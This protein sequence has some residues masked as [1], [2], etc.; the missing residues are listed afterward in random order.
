VTTHRTHADES[1]TDVD[2]D[3][4]P[5]DAVELE[6]HEP[7][8]L[9][10]TPRT[11]GP[12]GAGGGRRHRKWF[13]VGVLVVLLAAIGF[14]VT[15]LTDATTYFYTADQAVTKKASLGERTFRIEGTVMNQPAK[16]IEA[17]DEHLS[18]IIGSKSARVP[19][20]Y[21]GGEPSSLFKQGE[22]VVLVGHFTGD[23]FASSQILVK[24]DAEY[25]AKHPDR[26]KPNQP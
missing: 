18:F 19:V 9:D 20:H 13:V 16:R 5:D 11:S 7:P 22:P 15:Q 14:L 1:R 25:K 23:T 4:D 2:A 26:V 17:G 10:L 24:H 6:P 8:P 12:A 3:A 21:S